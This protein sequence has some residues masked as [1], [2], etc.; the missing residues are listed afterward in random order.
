MYLKSLDHMG[1][2][3]KQADKKNFAAK[4]LVDSIKTKH[5][6]Q[7]R[8]RGSKGP[9]PKYQYSYQ[10]TDQEVI[11]NVLHIMIVYASNANQHSSSERRRISDFFE[12]FISVFFDLT[13]EFV[14]AYTASIDRGTPDD[15]YED[16]A[17]TELSNGRGRRPVNGKKGDLRRG[18]LDKGRNGTRAR[19]Q[20]D[21]SATGSK[22]STPDV[23][24]NVDDEMPEV[25]ED[26][27]ITEVTN[28]RWAAV[29]SAVAVQ[30]TKPLES[31]DVEMKADQPFQRDWYNLYCNQTVFVFF[32][33]FQTLYQRFKDIKDAEAAARAEV[34]RARS[35]KPAK[36]IGLLSERLDHFT[37]LEEH[38]SYY[39]RVLDLVEDYIKGEVEEAKYQDFLRH[40]YLQT[41]WKIYTVTDLLKTLCRLGATCSSPDSKEKTPDLIEQFIR[42][43]ESKETSFNV[44][45]N[46]RKQADKYIKDGELFLI[47]WVSII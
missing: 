30:G 28:E 22:E 35:L 23:D 36:Q 24:S 42:N 4:H 11:G 38:E 10:F 12:K 32:S 29:P 13:D 43:R 31:D 25:G 45:I 44:E 15:E 6:E 27:A 40:Y 9:T 8:L 3:V 2:H 20:K 34:E 37:N 26:R 21:E 5:E 17:P 7:R 14:A 33:I 1:I 41:G 19:G 18:V 39:S 47:R 16:I 46:L